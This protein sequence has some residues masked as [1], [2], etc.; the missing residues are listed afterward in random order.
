MEW[1][2]SYLPSNR[3][4]RTIDE[5]RVRQLAAHLAARIKTTRPHAIRMEVRP[6]NTSISIQ[7]THKTA[8]FA[9]EQIDKGKQ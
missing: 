6:L 8:H 7:P 9:I 2:L 4:D 5:V 3:T 1:L